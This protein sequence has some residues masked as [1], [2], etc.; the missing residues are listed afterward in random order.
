MPFYLLLIFS[1]FQ[2]FAGAVVAG[3]QYQ[4][5]QIVDPY[6]ELQTGS[7]SGYP[8]FY[9]VERGGWIEIIKRKTD[10]FKVRAN[11]KTGWVRREQLEQTLTP[12]GKKL[13]IR[14][15]SI[16]DFLRRDW[17]MGLS[18]GDYN[19]STIITAYSGYA[20]SENLSVELSLSHVLGKYSSSIL[21]NLDLLA[22][23]FPEWRVSPYFALG[24]GKIKTSKR[25]VL[26]QTDDETDTTSHV[27]LGVRIYLSKRYILRLDYKNFV[28]FKSQDKNQENDTWQIGFAVFY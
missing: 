5:V 26:A 7:G 16:N 27:G 18:S 20:L 22:H 6:I 25:T 28:V 17:E 11:G 4:Q 19:G 14:D 8:V 1:I 12:A 3:E 9:V 21:P 23:P 13:D 2:M 15:A 10:W 24:T